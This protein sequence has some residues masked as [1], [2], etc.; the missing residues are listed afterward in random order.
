MRAYVEERPN[1][2]TAAEKVQIRE[3]LAEAQ[4]ER[5]AIS[6]ELK[7][8]GGLEAVLKGLATAGRFVIDVYGG[9]P[10]L[11]NMVAPLA[12][13]ERLLEG[14]ESRRELDEEIK[15]CKSRLYSVRCSAY[16]VNSVGGLNLVLRFVVVQF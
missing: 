12:A 15:K 13:A 6:N 16:T 14:L 1:A 11:P 2:P 7:T 10:S 3:R 5:E 9:T 4:A 8:L